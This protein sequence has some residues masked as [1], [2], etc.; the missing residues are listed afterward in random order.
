MRGNPFVKPSRLAVAAPAWESQTET[1][2][3]EKGHTSTCFSHNRASAA[4]V[5]VKSS[6]VKSNQAK[7][8]HLQQ[9]IIGSASGGG[10]GFVVRPF[11]WVASS[12]L[13]LPSIS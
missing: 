9:R 2:A 1:M 10:A 4:T 11:M 3:D 12:H 5:A 7:S 6:Q 13:S 8:N